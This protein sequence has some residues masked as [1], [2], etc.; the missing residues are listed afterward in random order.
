[1]TVSDPWRLVGTRLYLVDPVAAA[2]RRV[3]VADF[4]LQLL[5]NAAQQPVLVFQ[6][7]E[8]PA[9]NRPV[10]PPGGFTPP[11]EDS[12]SPADTVVAGLNNGLPDLSRVRVALVSFQG[13]TTFHS[14]WYEEGEDL[15]GFLLRADILLHDDPEFLTVVPVDPQ[16]A[17]THFTLLLCPR[18]WRSVDI[19]AFLV[20]DSRPDRAPF[21]MTAFQGQEA[22]D[23]LP[24]DALPLQRPCA[25][26]A[27]PTDARPC[28]GLTADAV[29][30]GMLL[31]GAPVCLQQLPAEDLTF[32]SARA[33]LATL[34]HIAPEQLE[35]VPV[36]QA[37]LAVFLRFGLDQFCLQLPFG[38]VPRHVAASLDIP[39]ESVFLCRQLD[40]FDR[41][42]VAGRR[43]SLCFGFRNLS[44]MGLPFQGAVWSLMPDHWADRCA[45]G[46]SWFLISRPA[47]YALGL[48]CLFQK[49]THHSARVVS[50]QVETMGPDL[51]TMAKPC[52]YGLTSSAP[53]PLQPSPMT[54]LPGLP[55]GQWMRRTPP[56]VRVGPLSPLPLPSSADSALCLWPGTR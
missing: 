2:I 30:S 56:A 23:A 8:V 38:S 19:R 48:R 44:D 5:E 20:T 33:H 3:Q 34:P 13:P 45:S 22:C 42:T 47:S 49:V 27:P 29:L 53:P 10:P 40:F 4:R 50:S 15:S 6:G 52:C 7:A 28:A 39:F 41:L 51:T 21:M 16:P 18:W 25:A 12:P 24:Q 11:D 54:A 43:P 37:R 26:V 35:P 9:P 32:N 36:P 17:P 1:M 46:R 55:L 31:D 14:L